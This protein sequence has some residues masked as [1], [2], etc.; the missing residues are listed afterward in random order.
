ML[1]GFQPVWDAQEQAWVERLSVALPVEPWS[2]LFGRRSARQMRDFKNKLTSLC[3]A[4]DAA[5]G[6]LD[7]HDA[8][9]RLRQVYREDFPVPARSAT[10][11]THLPAIASSSSGA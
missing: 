10:A 4:L 9:T 2:D 7:P 3:T 1:A 8:C 6:D 5:A 11:K